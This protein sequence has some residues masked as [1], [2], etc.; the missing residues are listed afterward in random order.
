MICT[1]VLN[2]CASPARVRRPVLEGSVHP[3]AGDS[4]LQ[5]PEEDD[6]RRRHLRQEYVAVD[7]T[8]TAAFE[9]GLGV[10]FMCLLCSAFGVL[11]RRM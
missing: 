10:Y 6:R 11:Y 9:E 5:A 3:A 7:G 1:A 8:L 4:L 2:L